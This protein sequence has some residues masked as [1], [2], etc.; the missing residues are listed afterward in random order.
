[1]ILCASDFREIHLVNKEAKFVIRE[2]LDIDCI[3]VGGALAFIITYLD[4][5]G[6]IRR[7]RG[8]QQNTRFYRKDDAT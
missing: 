4:D 2:P 3:E 7:M 8:H 1:M 6:L 5:D